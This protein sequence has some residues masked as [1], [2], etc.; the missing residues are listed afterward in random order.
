VITSELLEAH[1]ACPT[2]CYLR[3]IGE[4]GSGNAYAAWDKARGESYR[5]EGIGRLAAGSSQ[6]LACGRIE[7]SRLK[8]ARWQLALDQVF[9][10][11]DLEARIHAVQQLSMRGKPQT[12]ELTPI[13]FVR[14]NKLSHAD[15]LM[16]GFEALVLSKILGQP[17]DTAKIIHGNNRAELK[18]RPGTVL[19]ELSK[20]IVEIRRLLAAASPPDLVLNRHC[21]GVPI[22]RRLQEE[23]D[24][25]GRSQPP[26]RSN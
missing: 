8:K 11:E 18:V 13:R 4:V 22:S 23:S 14:T 1:L 17:V 20:V 3:S 12:S 15:R 6:D 16:A 2:K 21:P 19:R 5:R 7:A 25:K 24:R 10:A 9:R 26:F